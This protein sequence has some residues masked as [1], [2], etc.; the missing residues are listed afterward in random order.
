MGGAH[1]KKKALKEKAETGQERR[2][3]LDKS[4]ISEK[5]ALASKVPEAFKRAYNAHKRDLMYRHPEAQVHGC[6]CTGARKKVKMREKDFHV[7]V[8][9]KGFR[10]A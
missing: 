2:N 8:K 4:D 6:M 10:G 1:S 7:W 9:D 5:I 3:S